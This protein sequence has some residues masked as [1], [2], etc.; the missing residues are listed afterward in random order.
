[1]ISYEPLWAT[2]KAKGITTYAM[3]YTYGVNPRTINNLKH[4]KSITMETLGRLCRI[5]KCTPNEVI[6]FL[7]GEE[8]DMFLYE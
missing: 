1:M 4:N 7:P 8:D 5:L 2:M 6:E 3:I